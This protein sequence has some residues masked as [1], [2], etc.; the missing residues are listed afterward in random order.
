MPGMNGADA[1]IAARQR[2]A[3]IPILF[4]SGF[5]DSDVLQRAVGT[6]PLLRKPF[7][8]AELAAAVRATLD[9]RF[10]SKR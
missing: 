2:C 3:G 8:T 10:A 5:V 9:E 6:A 1:A 4:I 7:R